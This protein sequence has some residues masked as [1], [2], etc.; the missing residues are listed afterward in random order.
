[1]FDQWWVRFSAKDAI[2]SSTFEGE[3]CSV[4]DKRS[5]VKGYGLQVMGLKRGPRGKK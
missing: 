3:I 2:F 4:E 1:M 5:R